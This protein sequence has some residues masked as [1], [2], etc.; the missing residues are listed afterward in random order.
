MARKQ[1]LWFSI[2]GELVHIQAKTQDGLFWHLKRIM[3]ENSGSMFEMTQEQSDA[4]QDTKL[5]QRE[6][7]EREKAAAEAEQR[8]APG[9][10]TPRRRRRRRPNVSDA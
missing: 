1:E 4:Q 3:V 7:R 6:D 2:N 5:L 9:S 8:P 10:E